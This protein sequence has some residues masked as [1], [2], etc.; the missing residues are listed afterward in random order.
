MFNKNNDQ[1][2]PMMET[3]ELKCSP[4]MPMPQDPGI[5]DLM[6]DTAGILT[7]VSRMINLFACEITADGNCSEEKRGINEPKCFRE[8]VYQVR[9]LALGIRGDLDNLIRKFR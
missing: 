6:Q 9:Q 2:T 5:Y 4:N 1:H 8:N 3:A 7:E